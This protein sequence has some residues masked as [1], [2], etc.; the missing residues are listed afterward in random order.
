MCSLPGPGIEPTSPALT[1][2]LPF[3]AP[4][5]KAPCMPFQVTGSLLPSLSDSITMD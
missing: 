1:G 5:G 2:G 4:P 3:T